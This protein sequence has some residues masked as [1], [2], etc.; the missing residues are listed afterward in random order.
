MKKKIFSNLKTLLK[1]AKEIYDKKYEETEVKLENK[2]DTFVKQTKKTKKLMYPKL[3]QC[4]QKTKEKLK[5]CVQRLDEISSE[6]A[7]TLKQMLR[8]VQKWI[9][10]IV[11]NMSDL[12]KEIPKRKLVAKFIMLS[13][14]FML[15]LPITT[16]KASTLTI[17]DNAD[18]I[19]DT[20]ESFLQDQ[21][22]A[23]TDKYDIDVLILTNKEETNYTDI[24]QY[25]TD[26]LS[27]EFPDSK[28]SIGIVFDFYNASYT[29]VPQGTALNYITESEID[30]AFDICDAEF[31][32][33]NPSVFTCCNE[34]IV[35]CF[36]SINE[37]HQEE[38]GL[39]G[40]IQNVLDEASNVSVTSENVDVDTIT[41]KN[42]VYINDL[43]DLLT[44]E[45]ETA[46]QNWVEK[47]YSKLDYNILFLTT[48][49]ADG[50][51]TMVYSDDYMDA[52]FPDT[53]ENIAFVIDMDNR[54][55][56]INTMGSS[57]ERINDSNINSALNAG[58]NEITDGNYY[59]CLQK[60][61]K[62]CLN[63]LLKES[64]FGTKFVDAMLRSIL[65]A[66]IGTVIIVVALLA[67]HK[68]AN[69]SVNTGCY[70]NKQEYEILH[71]DATHVR[72]YT[73][74]QKDY[75]RPKSSSSGGGSSH[76]SSSGRSHGGGGRHF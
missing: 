5:E 46:L 48:N 37:T 10:S 7:V 25:A 52:M 4:Y 17:H 47:N 76:H 64:D 54:E 29:I 61:S 56:Y 58:Y 12:I 73:T 55:I 16:V 70:E 36:H 28:C 22:D 66:I 53:D 24:Y 6:E 21:I 68:K 35:S 62:Y 26:A 20:E 65:F 49:D 1:K 74:V 8:F 34:I 14:V 41:K 63:I 30:A 19:T 39:D 75:Y 44:E 50:K 32:K 42:H 9:I 40:E 69:K 43:A 18:S 71:K 67:I 72:S 3:T 57:I 51:S 11:K 2:W 31:K 60:M 13:L 23:L 15:M 45:E 27:K 59:K 33:T 38:T